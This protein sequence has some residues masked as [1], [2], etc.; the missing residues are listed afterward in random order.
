MSFAPFCQLSVAAIVRRVGNGRKHVDTIFGLK[1]IAVIFAASF[2]KLPLASVCLPHLIGH[3][4]IYQ[5]LRQRAS[6]AWPAHPSLTNLNLENESVN[7]RLFHDTYRMKPADFGEILEALH[8]P[9]IMMYPN[10]GTKFT[11]TTGLLVLLARLGIAG[12]LHGLGRKLRTN[13][14]R[15]S[16][17]SVM[18]MRH[19]W[20]GNCCMRTKSFA[21]AHLRGRHQD[22]DCCQPTSFW[23]HRLHPQRHSAG[24]I[25]IGSLI[26]RSPKKWPQISDCCR[27]GWVDLLLGSARARSA[28]GQHDSR[29]VRT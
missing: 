12:A 8:L 29:G 17:I 27:P 9:T 4:R 13:P 6:R 10:R 19:R 24:E 2:R 1:T 16:K 22:K 5:R 21:A 15:I 28:R 18:W 26:F 14:G 20:G 23:L 7:E 3:L 25:W 11:W